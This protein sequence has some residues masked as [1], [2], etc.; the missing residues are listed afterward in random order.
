M[1]D[2][3]SSWVPEFP[4]R[5]VS[6]WPH[7][8][9]DFERF[10]GAIATVDAGVLYV[11][12]SV[13]RGDGPT[14]P[15]RNS[16]P[17]KVYAPGYWATF[18]HIGDYS[19]RPN[20]LEQTRQLV[21]HYGT[22]SE[23]MADQVLRMKREGVHRLA[24]PPVSVLPPDEESPAEQTAEVPVYRD[25]TEQ[26]APDLLDEENG[27][28]NASSGVGAVVPRPKADDGAGGGVAA[29]KEEGD[30][31]AS[32]DTDMSVAQYIFGGSWGRL[33]HWR[34]GQLSERF[35]G[36]R[37]ALPDQSPSPTHLLSPDLTR[38]RIAEL[39]LAALPIS[40]MLAELVH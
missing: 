19:W 34:P 25:P 36:A 39:S 30:G 24:G 6:V 10:D 12:R 9:G 26:L 15:D 28:V 29:P 11:W 17:I 4:E 21:E 16:P 22:S 38:F 2:E 23:E 27:D 35:R 1:N 8:L 20:L 40:V 31:D 3:Q 37:P 13:K 14:A 5:Y 33:R 32:P 18:E 7:T